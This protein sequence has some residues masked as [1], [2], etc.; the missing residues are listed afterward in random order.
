MA[1]AG[2]PSERRSA[3]KGYGN[4]NSKQG[5]TAMTVTTYEGLYF[6]EA[7]DKEPARVVPLKS[8]FESE[9]MLEAKHG[10]RE[11]EKRVEVRPM[12]NPAA[13]DKGGDR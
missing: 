11:G 1:D 13:L 12:H 10:V 7:D 9:A 8:E 6:R 4:R 2:G 5:I 3:V